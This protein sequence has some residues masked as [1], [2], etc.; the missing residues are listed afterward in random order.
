MAPR[1][2][3]QGFQLLRGE[4]HRNHL[5]RFR[6]TPPEDDLFAAT[7]ELPEGVS[8]A[9]FATALAGPKHGQGERLTRWHLGLWENAD[10]TEQ[11]HALARS[12]LSNTA[13][14]ARMRDLLIGEGSE[15]EATVAH[16]PAG[17]SLAMA[18]LLRVA[19]IRYLSQIP[20]LSEMDFQAVVARTAPAVQH[21]LNAHA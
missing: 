7:L 2:S 3:V 12:S 4:A 6:P 8:A 19:F 16:D 17:M 15:F 14:A 18:H 1:G 10:T 9:G 21:H 5:R 11:M 20:P 13:A